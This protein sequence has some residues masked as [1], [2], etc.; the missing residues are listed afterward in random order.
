MSALPSK[1]D[2]RR[3]H[4]D[5]DVAARRELKVNDRKGQHPLPR[6]LAR[7]RCLGLKAAMGGVA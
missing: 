1:A 6:G 2:V 3:A 5:E 7:R 4:S